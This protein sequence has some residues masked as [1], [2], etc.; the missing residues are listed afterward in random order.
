MIE[1]EVCP[2]CHSESI[3]Y[4]KDMDEWLDENTL[5][6]WYTYECQDCGCR[7]VGDVILTVSS[8][9]V[10]LTDEEVQTKIKQELK[11]RY[12]E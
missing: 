1:D 7:F 12:G 6:I 4:S 8:R 9:I 3:D 10:G 2:K 5:R 11:E